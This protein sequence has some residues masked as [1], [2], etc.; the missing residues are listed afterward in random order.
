MVYE[1]MLPTED[2]L[3]EHFQYLQKSDIRITRQN[4][5]ISTESVLHRQRD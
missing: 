5:Q 3:S 2:Y 1:T 4:W